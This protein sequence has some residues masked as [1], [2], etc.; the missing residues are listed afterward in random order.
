V[1]PHGSANDHTSDEEFSGR[2]AFDHWRFAE[3]DRLVH[4]DW[5]DMGAVEKRHWIDRGRAGR[6][7]SE[8]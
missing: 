2:R 3:T 8:R 1:L 5:A 6:P 7:P 4:W